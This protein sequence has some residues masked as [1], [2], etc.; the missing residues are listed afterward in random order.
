[1]NG[2]WSLGSERGTGARIPAP[3]KAS[4]APMPP[5]PK[6]EWDISDPDPALFGALRRAAKRIALGV[7]D[8]GWF[9]LTPLETH[10]V[11]CGFPRSGSTLL[12]VMIETCFAG[13]KVFSRETRG[14]RM[15]HYALRNQTVMITK[16]PRDVFWMDDIRAFY[17]R[18]RAKARF[19]LTIRDPR[20]V[21]TSYHAGWAER[22]HYLT[23]TQWRAHY[24]H[25]RYA[26]RFEDT[27]IVEFA[28]LVS[29]PHG[30]QKRLSEYAGCAV[31][32]PFDQFHLVASKDRIALNGIRPLDRSAIDK[33]RDPKHRE[34]MRRLLDEIPE[35]P[36]RIIEMGYETDTRWTADYA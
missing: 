8:R 32:R 5:P 16:R 26:R 24:E 11:V 25:Y 35:L 6:P 36:E 20:A 30:V 19:V 28:D 10:L 29:D 27:M 12:Q 2:N 21:L 3:A 31:E 17:A 14:L 18:R 15:A 23:P 4:V 9:G 13:A 33:W 7:V 1:M 34:R 22:G